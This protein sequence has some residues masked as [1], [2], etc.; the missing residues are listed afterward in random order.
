MVLQCKKYLINCFAK[1]S[2]ENDQYTSCAF[3]RGPRRDPKWDPYWNPKGDPKGD[4]KGDPK[5]DSKWGPNQKGVQN[6]IQKRLE[7]EVTKWYFNARN[8]W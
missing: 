6:G 1:Y 4:L 3:L 2:K 8:T 5:G 7:N